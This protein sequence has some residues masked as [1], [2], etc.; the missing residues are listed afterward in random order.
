MITNQTEVMSARELKMLEDLLCGLMLVVCKHFQFAGTW[1][2]RV[3][4]AM[5]RA[6]GNHLL[7]QCVVAEPEI[8]EEEVDE[9]LSCWL[10]Q[11]MGCGMLSQRR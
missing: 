3:V 2:V 5:S 1:K 10:L 11:A 8:R 4:L 9:H 6:F 7:K